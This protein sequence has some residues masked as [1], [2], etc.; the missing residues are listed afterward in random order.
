L[1]V[2]CDDASSVL[3]HA[4]QK[5]G[6]FKIWW[7][8]YWSLREAAHSFADLDI[9]TELFMFSSDLA[10]RGVQGWVIWWA[11]LELVHLWVGVLI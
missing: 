4:S 11:F 5:V 3:L 10:T 6:R 9:A 8:F 1:C 7:E 2:S